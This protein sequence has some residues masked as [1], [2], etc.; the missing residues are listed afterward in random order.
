MLPLTTNQTEV[1]EFIIGFIEKNNY[2][3]T[4][5]EI[6]V[7]VGIKNIGLVHK[8][9]SALERKRYLLKEKRMPRG[10]MLTEVSENFYN[11]KGAYKK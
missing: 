3:P 4:L 8:I 9:I 2:P 10:L 7:G 5:R 1:L 6:Q 11:S